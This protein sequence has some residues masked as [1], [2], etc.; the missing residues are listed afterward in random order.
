MT[1]AELVCR[2]A[3]FL[4]TLAL[5]RR[6]GSELCGRL[7]FAFG[8]VVWLTML[9][10]DGLEVIAAREIARHPRLIRPLVGLILAV[11]GAL[12]AG[13]YAGLVGAGALSLSTGTERATLA[14]YGLLLATTALGVDFVFRG[15]ERMGLLAASLVLRSAVYALGVAFWVVRPDRLLWVPAFLVF[16][17]L[18]GIALVWAVYLRRYGPPRPAFG[19][20]ALGVLIK[21]GRSVYVIQIA[22]TVVVSVDLLVVNLVFPYR[23][24][25]LYSLPHRMATVALTFGLILQQ[26]I[27]PALA[28]SWRGRPDAARLALDASVRV[29]MIGLVPLAVGATVLAGPLVRLLHLP[30]GY[31]GAGALLALGIWRAPLLTLAYLY[32]TALIAL[33]RESAG[34]GLLVGGAIG[35]GPVVATLGWA[36][37]LSGAAAGVIVIGLALVGAG[38]W[39][40]ARERRQPAWHHHLGLPLLASAAMIPACLA[41]RHTH[42]LIAVLGGALAYLLALAALG[43]LRRQ[44]IEAL[45]GR[46]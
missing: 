40:L 42:V 11:K 35:A 41:L 44:D 23:A 36:F 45:L 14:L 9:V 39:R 34:A 12:A 28:R 27:F 29:L 16:G 22:Q 21:R 2:A 46:G 13:L 33:N 30:A 43:G 4:V 37:G 38:Y 7:E 1:A 18:C 31:D 24:I 26:V 6:L 20:L 17:E 19:G 3:T 8:V 25:G 5:A 10:R 15:T 32:Q